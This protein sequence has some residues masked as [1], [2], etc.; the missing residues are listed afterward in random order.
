M[1]NFASNRKLAVNDALLLFENPS[2][3]T[4]LKPPPNLILIRDSAGYV[5]SVIDELEGP[6]YF[7]GMYNSTTRSYYFRLTRHVQKLIDGYYS[8]N[9]ELYIQV[10]DPLTSTIYPNRVMINGYNPIPGSSSSRFRLLIT[11]TLLN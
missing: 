2:T 7:G 10:N 4:T 5:G 8:K 6:N 11:Y 9:R 1:K 3:D